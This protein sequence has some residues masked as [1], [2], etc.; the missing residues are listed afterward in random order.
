VTGASAAPLRAAPTT[1]RAALPWMQRPLGNTTLPDRI[2]NASGVAVSC[3][4]VAAGI[5]NQRFLPLGREQSSAACCVVRPSKADPR[6]VSAASGRHIGLLPRTTSRGCRPLQMSYH[7][8]GFPTR[9]NSRYRALICRLAAPICPASR[10]ALPI[11]EFGRELEI[12]RRSILSP[13][14]PA[15]RCATPRASQCPQTEHAG[16]NPDP[17]TF[18]APWTS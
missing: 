15:P 1:C 5:R 9:D 3:K 13:A 12:Q 6:R 18:T 11:V 2:F 8:T 17:R 14:A 16:V 4:S 10:H 7:A